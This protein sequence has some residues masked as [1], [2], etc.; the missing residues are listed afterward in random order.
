MISSRC[1]KIYKYINIYMSKGRKC[2]ER[3]REGE[4]EKERERSFS[5]AIIILDYNDKLQQ[6]WS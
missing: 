4:R 5:V 1:K 3:E 2:K 6:V